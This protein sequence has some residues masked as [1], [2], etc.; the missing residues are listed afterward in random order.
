MTR[1]RLATTMTLAIG[2]ATASALMGCS[3]TAPPTSTAVLLPETGGKTGAMVVR[4]GKSETVVDQP[5]AAA[6]VGSAGVPV[7]VR[8]LSRE[9]V[10]KRFGVTLAAEPAGPA[11]FTLYFDS[12]GTELTAESRALLP[13]VV[14]AYTARSPA[15]VFII[16]HTDQVGGDEANLKLS[17]ERAREV[18]RILRA[19]RADFDRI[20]VRGFGKNDPLVPAP[21]RAAEPRNRRV[22]IL[23][24]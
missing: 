12:G 11:S 6:T 19:T 2:L 7:Q 18:E 10:E 21:D 16:G 1:P 22:E 4:D 13:A 5:Y 20:E 3:T 17:L 9:E 15:K 24:L 14:E 8:V 23:I